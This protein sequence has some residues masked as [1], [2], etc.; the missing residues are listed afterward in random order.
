MEGRKYT[1]A[2]SYRYGFNGKENDGEVKG[3]GNQQD[4]GKRIYDPRVG[5]FL[6]VDP[7][8]KNFPFYTPYQFAGNMPIWA[9][10]LDGAEPLRATIKEIAYSN[11]DNHVV[12]T[13]EI[14][15]KVQVINMS[16]TANGDLDLSSIQSSVRQNFASQFY[17]THTA[18]LPSAHKLNLKTKNPEI[19]STYNQQYTFNITNVNIQTEIINSADKLTNDA[20]VVGVVDNLH[21]RKN[22]KGKEIDPIGL[23]NN[24]N[25]IV[26]VEADEVKLGKMNF[27]KGQSLVNHE[28][29]H[30]FNLGH[31][32]SS[33]NVMYETL[34]GKTQFTD[35][36][37]VEMLRTALGNWQYLWDKKKQG[38]DLKLDNRR[39]E[40]KQEGSTG[41]QAQRFATTQEKI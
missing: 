19:V 2:D 14:T 12:I 25:A 36:Q 41:E 40:G 20:I 23:T 17:G 16:S 11:K 28:L 21:P 10:D 18:P 15:I 33:S 32:P 39:I 1:A 22:E 35:A 34:S 37:I 3:E 9:I 27:E 13:G 29:G 5:R 4:Y 38:Q 7:L 31:D 6:S 8:T 26:L 30:T 24:F